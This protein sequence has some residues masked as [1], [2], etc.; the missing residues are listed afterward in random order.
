MEDCSGA[1]RTHILPLSRIRLVAGNAGIILAFQSPSSLTGSVYGI[2]LE[3][4]SFFS[5]GIPQGRI[6]V[7]SPVKLYR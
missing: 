3:E 6:P 1:A 2:G 4:F 7:H 5:Q